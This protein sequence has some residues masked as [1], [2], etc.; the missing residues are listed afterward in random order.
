MKK[1]DLLRSLDRI[2]P[3]E[4]LIRST[5]V[6][7]DDHKRRASRKGFQKNLSFATR[8]VGALCSLALVF[9]IGFAVAMQNTA[10]DTRTIG[11]LGGTAPSTASTTLTSPLE[12]LEL[13]RGW[14]LVSGQINNLSF[15]TLTDAD[16][17][18]GILRRCKVNLTA[19]ALIARSSDIAVDLNKTA[20]CLDAFILFNSDDKMNSFFDMSISEM[21]FCLTPGESGEWIIVDFE[22]FEK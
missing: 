19:D 5:I 18:S 4:E 17:Q 8:L 7:I 9:S 1:T 22:L 11:Q 6:K 12:D 2:Q 14:I 20:S 15:D 21:I 3:S 13:P 16:A 10:P